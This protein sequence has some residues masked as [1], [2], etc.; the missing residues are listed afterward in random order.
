MASGAVRHDIFNRELAAPNGETDEYGFTVGFLDNRLT[1]RANWFETVQAIRT[2]T[3]LSGQASGAIPFI[4]NRVGENGRPV[5][6]ENFYNQ[7]DI[8]NLANY[9]AQP[10]EIIDAWQIKDDGTGTGAMT[11][12]T[13]TN[14]A[15]TS[16][17]VSTGFELELVGNLTKN[18]TAVFNAVQVEVSRDNSGAELYEYLYGKYNQVANLTQDKWGKYP[19]ALG[20]S[21][22]IGDRFELTHEGPFSACKSAGWCWIH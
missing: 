6:D 10:Q 22:N 9:P 17:A 12:T 19:S 5:I 2:E 21:F 14:V 15:A 13:P 1:F 11:W 3:D 7:A 4:L 16:D 20:N 18:W 8:E